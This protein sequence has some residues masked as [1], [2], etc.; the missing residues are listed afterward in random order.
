LCFVMQGVS[1]CE[2][3]WPQNYTSDYGASEL[4]WELVS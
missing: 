2:Q 3:I 1:K 4:Q